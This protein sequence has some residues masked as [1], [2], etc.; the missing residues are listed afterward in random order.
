MLDV[1]ST[2]MDRFIVAYTAFCLFFAWYATVEL[3]RYPRA[4]TAAIYAAMLPL[5]GLWLAPGFQASRAWLIERMNGTRAA[6]VSLAIFLVPYVIYVAGTGDF[7]AR[8]LVKLG[9]FA[10]LP[11]MLFAVSGVRRPHEMNWDDALILLWLVL[12]MLS[13]QL[14]GIWNVPLEQDSMARMF[15]T[16]AG[17][18]AFLIL[19]R[20]EGSGYEFHFTGGMARDVVLNL[21][22]FAAIAL[23]LGFA[24]RFIAW[25]PR[26]RGA[27]GFVAEFAGIFVFIAVTEEF[28]FRGVLQ[29]LLECSVRSRYVGQGLAS[30]LF[31]L[32]HVQH[33]PVPNWRYVAMASV[34]GWFYG[35]AYRK[36]RNIMASAATHAL[37][38]TLWRTFF[39][40]PTK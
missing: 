5:L 6:I 20:L 25:N 2:S 23:P 27:A 29:N 35:S 22:G 40:L 39:T 15:V 3:G 9:A 33:A 26:W 1:D 30:V 18:W 10:A 13:G 24:L 38:D 31:G 12:P 11:F 14:S 8:A 28:F 21:A 16:A 17:A 37:V 36:R 4:Q 34:A 19:R 32:S 7:R